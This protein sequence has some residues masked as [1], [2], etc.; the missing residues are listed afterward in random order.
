MPNRQIPAETEFGVR[1]IKTKTDKLNS[2]SKEAQRYSRN[3]EYEKARA[4][5]NK[6]LEL[7][8]NSAAAF[9]V[10]GATYYSQGRTEQAIESIDKAIKIIEM[11]LDPEEIFSG[12][13]RSRED[14][15]RFLK[16][17]IELYRRNP[18]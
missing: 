2:Y 7:N 17:L 13:K 1:E 16:E 11:N 4:M 18:R 9:R 14:S 15:I 5:V 6:M 8:P 12:D 10:L 3:R